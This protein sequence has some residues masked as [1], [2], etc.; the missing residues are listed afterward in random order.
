MAGLSAPQQ[1]LSY[2][3]YSCGYADSS[4]DALGDPAAVRRPRP[5]SFEALRPD[6]CFRVVQQHRRHHLNYAPRPSSSRPLAPPQVDCAECEAFAESWVATRAADAAR[7]G[8]AAFMTE[9]GACSGSETCL[10]EL[11][12]VADQADTAM[13]SWAYWQFK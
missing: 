12:R 7:L 13:H 11:D 5:S 3:I 8:A 4:C 10:A 2:H 6:R 1:A 9:F